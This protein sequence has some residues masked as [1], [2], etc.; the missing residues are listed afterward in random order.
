MD[1]YTSWIQLTITAILLGVIFSS[2]K[3]SQK[4]TQDDIQKHVDDA[5]SDIDKNIERETATMKESIKIAHA[6]IDEST[7]ER[8]NNYLTKEFHGMLCENRMHEL[9]EHVTF[10]MNAIFEAIR[11]LDKKIDKLD[12]RTGFLKDKLAKE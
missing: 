11:A 2:L 3:S 5:Q 12:G 8:R 7:A 9:K 1:E 4:K 10:N 6:R